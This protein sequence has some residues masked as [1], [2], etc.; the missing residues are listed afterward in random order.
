MANACSIT[1]RRPNELP[2]PE[3]VENRRRSI[4]MLPSGAPALK[5]MTLL[6]QLELARIE[7]RKLRAGVATRD[8]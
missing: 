5:R 3:L 7:V 4:A 2:F 6:E 8:L 1:V